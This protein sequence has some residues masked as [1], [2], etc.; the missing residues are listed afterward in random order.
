MSAA[1]PTASPTGDVVSSVVIE[2]TE[3]DLTVVPIAEPVELAPWP[4]SVLPR[5]N[6]PAFD[7]ALRSTASFA[8]AREWH[9]VET[10]ASAQERTA[11]GAKRG[12]APKERPQLP[13][14]PVPDH[15]LPI[16][17]MPG[18]S[19]GAGGSEGSHAGTVGA[20]LCAFL[21]LLGLAASRAVTALERRLTPARLVSLLERPG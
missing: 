9:V 5:R 20:L 2:P 13:R 7:S 10:S 18:T 16:P 3:E 21:G 14:A 19:A 8:A 4:S 15:Q 12:G 6:A 17:T 1:Q 11:S